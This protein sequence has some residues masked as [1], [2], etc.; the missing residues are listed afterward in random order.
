MKA[1]LQKLTGTSGDKMDSIQ[2]RIPESEMEIQHSK[3]DIMNLRR[4][5]YVDITAI[6]TQS[7]LEGDKVSFPAIKFQSMA[8]SISL[9][10]TET[11]QILTL[12]FSLEDDH[13]VFDDVIRYG[14]R[15]KMVEVNFSEGV[16][17][18]SK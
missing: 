12:T 4:Y 6:A 14:L 17:P 16:N 5:H 3:N 15:G 13:S 2:I 8:T 10:M 7:Q 18:Y 9:C 11:G 1:I